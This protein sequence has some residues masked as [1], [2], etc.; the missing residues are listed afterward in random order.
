MLR[1]GAIVE[2]DKDAVRSPE[3]L[4]VP[5][6]RA[7]LQ[8]AGFHGDRLVVDQFPHGHSNLTDLVRLDGREWVLRRPPF[9]KLPPRAHDM[10]REFRILSALTDAYP[11]APRPVLFWVGGE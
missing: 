11:L 5:A 8:P 1:P 2:Q 3:P 7:Y 6:L 10:A 9:G 4:P